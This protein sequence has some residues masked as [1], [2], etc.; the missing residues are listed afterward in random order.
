MTGSND[1]TPGPSGESAYDALLAGHSTARDDAGDHDVF[2]DF[3]DDEVTGSRPARRDPGRARRWAVLG[4]AGALVLGGLILA[5]TMLAP[6]ISGFFEDK[7]YEGPGSGSVSAVV[8]EGDTG[9]AIGQTLTKAGV[10]KT[11]EAFEKALAENPGDEIQPGT[12]SL[13]KEMKA[14]DAV[15]LL[16]SG[17][18]RDEVTATIR[19][20]L[21]ATEVYAELSKATGVPV[22]D[23]AKAAKNPK[24]LG[25][26]AAAKGNTEGYLFPATYTF[27]PKASAADQLKEL[28]GQATARYSALGVEPAQMHDIITIA[29]IVEAEAR[30]PTDRPKVAAVIE[31]RLKINMPLQLDSTVSYGAGKRTIT[32]TD[33]ERADDNPYNTYVHPGLPKGP[34]TNPGADAV[35]A[36]LHPAEGDWLY[37]VAINPETGETLFAKTAAEHNAN[38]RK[39]QAWCQANPGKC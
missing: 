38:V 19:E 35:K 29:S 24:A 6:M 18:A 11:S 36:A 7:D 34:I 28:V 8:H 16:R 9:R 20:G 2:D 5:Y 26:P 22:A 32:T 17:A 15:T 25:L 3:G 33:A 13:K 4:V 14:A 30:I 23:Y 27:A 37:F 31:N 21:R 12:Y 39:F 10:V 1:P